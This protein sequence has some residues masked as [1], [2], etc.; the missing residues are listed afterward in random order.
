MN[1]PTTV[2]LIYDR[3]DATADELSDAVAAALASDEL[4]GRAAAAG[5]EPDT[6]AAAEI[7]VR[8]GAQGVEP[9]LTAIVVGITVRAAEG[10]AEKAW[11][12]VI[13]PLVRRT[14]GARAL[15]PRSHRE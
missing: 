14:L 4:A 1:A 6:V 2:E 12:E 9:I 13:W 11:T 3:G 7:S 10:I 8:E 15:L 5:L